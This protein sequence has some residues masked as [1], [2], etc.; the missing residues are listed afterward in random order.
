MF[1]VKKI[2]L[3]SYWAF[4]LSDFLLSPKGP[5]LIP[6]GPFSSTELCNVVSIVKHTAITGWLNP[7]KRNWSS[8]A[9]QPLSFAIAHVECIYLWPKIHWSYPS[10]TCFLPY[11][12][13]TSE[14]QIVEQKSQ[15]RVL[16][17]DVDEAKGRIHEI[18]KEMESV[19]E[20]LG[21]AKVS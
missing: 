17:S 14:Q 11:L 18:Q 10:N 6:I 15:E 4:L 12:F 16:A 2:G 7:L 9:P 20:Q 1:S 8:H 5:F 3:F 13:R 21:E 19:I